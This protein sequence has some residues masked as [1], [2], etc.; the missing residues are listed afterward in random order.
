MYFLAPEFLWLL[1]IVPG[2][3]LLYLWLMQRKKKLALRYAS[4]AIVKQ[5]MAGDPSW[6]RHLPPALLLAAIGLALLASSRPLANIP[7]PTA[8]ATIIL[9]MDVSLSMRATDVKPNRLVASQEAAKTFLAE[10]PPDI[11]VGIV[12][13]AGSTQLVQAPTLN[14]ESLVTA[15]DRFQMQGGSGAVAAVVPPDRLRLRESAGQR[16]CS[17]QARAGR[18]P[19]TQ[20]ASTRP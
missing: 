11:K 3:V 12:T 2:L 17:G 14:R 1:L 8:G 19:H 5:A 9:A 10:L 7:L 4:L 13:F 18:L 20:D 15:I 6:R 16:R